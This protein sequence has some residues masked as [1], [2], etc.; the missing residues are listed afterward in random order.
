MM[1]R[2]SMSYDYKDEDDD[3]DDL[4]KIEA[5]DTI[6]VIFLLTPETCVFLKPDT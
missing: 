1:L 6:S 2:K 5:Q 4:I 3:K